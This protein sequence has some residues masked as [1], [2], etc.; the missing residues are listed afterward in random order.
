M[1][2]PLTAVGPPLRPWKEATRRRLAKA[3]G[4]DAKARRVRSYGA[5]GQVQRGGGNVA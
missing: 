3:R 1:D 5:T 2:E 4:M